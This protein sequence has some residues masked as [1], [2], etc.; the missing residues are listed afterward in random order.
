MNLCNTKKI[1]DKFGNGRVNKH[2]SLYK[3]PH[4]VE[5]F[6]TIVNI[7]G[8]GLFILKKELRPIQ[9]WRYPLAYNLNN[10]MEFSFL[11]NYILDPVKFGNSL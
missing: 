3:F 9:V 6:G 7:F 1:S 8:D 5:Y 10:V 4:Q 2:L 11:T